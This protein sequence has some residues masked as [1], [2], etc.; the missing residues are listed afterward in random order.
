MSREKHWGKM[1]ITKTQDYENKLRNKVKIKGLTKQKKV[2]N[3]CENIV[4]TQ[5]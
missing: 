4:V 2:K 3:K 5:Y 1:S